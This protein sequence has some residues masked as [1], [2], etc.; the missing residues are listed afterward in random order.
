MV[1]S[2]V[3]AQILT[4]RT[5]PSRLRNCRLAEHN[6]GKSVHTSQFKPW[7]LTACIALPEKLVADKLE[8]YLNS[9]SGHALAIRRLLTKYRHRS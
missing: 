5:N 7:D 8:K 6:A 2:D 4:L 1:V 9:G 3:F